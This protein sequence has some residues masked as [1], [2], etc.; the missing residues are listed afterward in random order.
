[1]GCD[2]LWGREDGDVVVD[3]G[4]VRVKESESLMLNEICGRTSW[5]WLAGW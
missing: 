1:L 4:L 5:V 3:S 2:V